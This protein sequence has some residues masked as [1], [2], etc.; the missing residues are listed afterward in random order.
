MAHSVLR[1]PVVFNFD[2]DFLNSSRV[3]FEAT[4][5][6]NRNGDVVLASF[7]GQP[8][9]KFIAKRFTLLN[10]ERVARNKRVFFREVQFMQSSDHPFL[11]KCIYAAACPMYLSIYMKYYHRGTLERYLGHMSLDMSELCVIQV[12]CAL[13]YLHKNNLVHLDVKLANIFLDEEHNAILGDF[14]L[15][16]EM[17]PQQ[18][19]LAKR[20]IGSTDG[21]AAPEWVAA[22]PDMELDPYKMD[23]YSLG[24]VLWCLVLE[25]VTGLDVNYYF[26]TRKTADLQP[27]IRDMLLRLLQWDPVERVTVGDFLHRVHWDSVYR[28]V[29]DRN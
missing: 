15:A 19:T 1:G 4:I 23:S 25:R 5:D 27:R 11:V 16:M 28:S 6:A 21:Y 22:S 17:E 8:N 12:A 26:E 20:F 29:I 13:R 10:E 7:W 18:Q 9:W 3:N 2:I 14:G 24:V